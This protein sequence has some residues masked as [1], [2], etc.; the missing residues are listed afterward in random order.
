[1]ATCGVVLIKST[2]ENREMVVKKFLYILPKAIQ[3]VSGSD[4]CTF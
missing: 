2:L 4:F 3:Y 1:M